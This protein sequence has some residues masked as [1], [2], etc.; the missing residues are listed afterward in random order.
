MEMNILS[1]VSFE[2]GGLWIMVD[3]HIHRLLSDHGHLNACWLWLR[4][5]FTHGRGDSVMLKSE[6]GVTMG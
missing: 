5:C 3:D 2:N 4:Y 6:W 1:T